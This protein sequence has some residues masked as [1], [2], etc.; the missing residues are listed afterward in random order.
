MGY[1]RRWQKTIPVIFG[2]PSF[3]GHGIDWKKNDERTECFKE[4]CKTLVVAQ[5]K[6]SAQIAVIKSISQ[7]KQ[8]ELHVTRV[9]QSA[10]GNP[11]E[12]MT[13]CLAVIYNT[14]KNYN[15]K[16]ILHDYVKNSWNDDI[17]NLNL[18]L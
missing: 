7:N 14:V 15:V 8:I 3:Q 11:K 5:Y 4:I 13:E 12:I 18:I 10:F 17:K 2:S 9:G 16:V 6:A 1:L